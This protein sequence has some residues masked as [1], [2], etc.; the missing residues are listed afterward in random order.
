MCKSSE[1]WSITRLAGDT[2]EGE[3]STVT[4]QAGGEG[5]TAGGSPAALQ[6]VRRHHLP[7]HPGTLVLPHKPRLARRVLPSIPEGEAVGKYFPSQIVSPPPNNNN[8]NNNRVCLC[9]GCCRD[10]AAQP[11]ALPRAAR[12][13]AER[14]SSRSGGSGAG[15]HAHRCPPLLLSPVGTELSSPRRH[16]HPTAVAPSPSLGVGLPPRVPPGHWWG[17]GLGVAGDLVGWSTQQTS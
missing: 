9:P 5:S 14:R 7:H 2:G 15:G 3:S 6:S 11:R 8:N 10:C 4:G 16:I 12:R 17:G 1:V 13:E